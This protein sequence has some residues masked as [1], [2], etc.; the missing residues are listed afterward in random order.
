MTL[1]DID[2]SNVDAIVPTEVSD[3][4]READ[5]RVSEFLRDSPDR[6]T[7]FVPSDFVTVYH[8][9]RTISEGHLASRNSLCEWG[10]GFGVV[11]SLAG[12]LGF[13]AYGME[14]DRDL[15]DA[16]RTL[17][18]EFSLPVEFVH[19]SFIPAGADACAEEAY[20]ESGTEFFWLDTDAADGYDELGL[21]PDDFAVVFAYPWPGEECLIVRLFEEYAAD[22]AL[23]L[24]YGQFNTVRLQRMVGKPTRYS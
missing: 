13:D 9:L 4:L 7:G 17:A 12:M 21:D 11:A 3:F 5:V 20:R 18:D 6:A 24:L 23:L 16:S 19:G 1:V 15:V 10:S 22:G 2:I 14:T 8:A